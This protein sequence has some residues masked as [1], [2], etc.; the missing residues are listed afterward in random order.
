MAFRFAPHHHPS[1]PGQKKARSISINC[2]VCI[3][4]TYA[5]YREDNVFI[6]NLC[7]FLIDSQSNLRL[8]RFAHSLCPTYRRAAARCFTNTN[9]LF[10][11]THRA[12]NNIIIQPRH[13]QVLLRTVDKRWKYGESFL[14]LTRLCSTTMGLLFAILWIICFIAMQFISII[15]EM[16]TKQMP[17]NK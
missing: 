8:F 9:T 6:R 17:K 4:G 5:A 1:Q 11:F 13:L 2:C 16:Q 12:Y 14:P 7:C 3:H 15:V 10:V